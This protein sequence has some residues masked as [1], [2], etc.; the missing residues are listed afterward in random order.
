MTGREMLRDAVWTA[1]VKGSS[2]G[3]LSYE[4]RMMAEDA[5]DAIERE[6]VARF[7]D[8]AEPKV[9]DALLA[10]G[11]AGDAHRVTRGLDPAEH[12]DHE[13]LFRP[14]AEADAAALLA[15]LRATV[16]GT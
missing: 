1:A 11:H 12:R 15:H 2:Q 9:A 13:C 5:A 3:V 14:V 7:L 16:E 4:T 6:A 8:T 10:T